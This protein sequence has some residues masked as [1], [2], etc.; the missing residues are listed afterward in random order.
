MPIAAILVSPEIADV[1]HSQSSKL[2][3]FAHGFTYSGHPVACVVAIE[4]LKIY[5]ERNITEH[6]NKIAPRFQEGIKA[7]SGSPIVGEIRGLGL[8]LGTEFVDNKSP[9]DPFPAEWGVGS[10]F[11]A[12]CEKRGMLIRVA[13]DNIMLS[14]PLI[15]TP[16]EVDEIVSKYG[17][18]LKATE[19]RIEELKSAKK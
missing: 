12:E 8:I 7:F 9:N 11:C 3:S 18:A 17:G 15:M 4:A 14:P 5:K 13:G 10:I 2:G 19:E 1:I 16:D 6:V